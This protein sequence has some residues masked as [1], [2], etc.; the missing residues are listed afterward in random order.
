M[1]FNLTAQKT[2]DIEEIKSVL[3][4]PVIL[5][6]ISEDGA[7]LKDIDVKNET[8]VSIKKKDITIGIYNLVPLNAITMEVHAHVLPEY[9]KEYSMRTSRIFYKWF[10]EN[11]DRL[12]LIAIVPFFHKNVQNFLIS[13]KFTVEGINRKSFRRNNEIM[14]QIM[15]GITR[16][17]I[18]IF[19]DA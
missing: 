12:K 10:L 3:G 14:D 19:L 15:F 6:A 16:K 5:E 2:E 18:E 9:R 7:K 4:H 1:D 8:W 17:E 13:N 11:T